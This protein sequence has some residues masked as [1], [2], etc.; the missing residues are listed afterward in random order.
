MNYK[1][2]TTENNLNFEKTSE[3][4]L[5]VKANF[6][7]ADTFMPYLYNDNLKYEKLR[8]DHL[9]SEDVKKMF[10]NKKVTLEHPDEPL[11][12]ETVGEYGKGTIVDVFE[13]G[14]FL[15]G[16]LQIENKDT[17][18]FIENKLKNNEKIQ[19]SAAYFAEDKKIDENKVE[20]SIKDVN[21]V[22]I[23]DGQGR[24]GEDVR[25]LLNGLTEEELEKILKINGGKKNME[26]RT[27]KFNGT[28]MEVEEIIAIASRAQAEVDAAKTTIDD[29][30]TKL[31]DAETALTT[32]EEEK[33]AAEEKANALEEELAAEKALTDDE[34]RGLAAPFY[35]GDL[36]NDP[37]D[38]IM[39]DIINLVF[40]EETFEG[41]ERE[42]LI[43]KFLQA[44]EVLRQNSFADPEE[45]KGETEPT[46][47]SNS[48]KFN[49]RD[50]KH[51]NAKA[52]KKAK[53][54]MEEK[55][56]RKNKNNK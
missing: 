19:V 54:R 41:V 2:N 10:L 26:K 20:Q 13:N 37:V 18:E 7:K 16:T 6:L 1:I 44:I 38:K 25:L 21:H 29:L 17:I 39:K 56:K 34:I 3:G 15:S 9:F 33:T 23:L 36:E 52:H 49:A 24:A 22:A 31:T 27:Y 30:N 46:E 42:A 55:Y 50:Y 48:W 8:K 40:P 43:D 28:E 45:A 53:N 35:N 11:T 4:Y 14:D 12:A 47:K 32:A 51:N 5:R